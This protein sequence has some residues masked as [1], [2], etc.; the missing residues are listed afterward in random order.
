MTTFD[1]SVNTAWMEAL[2]MG[3][4]RLYYIKLDTNETSWECPSQFLVRA[5][6]VAAHATA[7]EQLRQH[8][9]ASAADGDDAAFLA[10][11]LERFPPPLTPPPAGDA[12]TALQAQV[13]RLEREK[14]ALEQQVTQLSAAAQKASAEKAALE[15]TVAQLNTVSASGAPPSCASPSGAKPP[16]CKR[17][18]SARFNLAAPPPPPPEWALQMSKGSSGRTVVGAMTDGGAATAP[19]AS[20]GIGGLHPPLNRRISGA[21]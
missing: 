19:S 4:G 10:R 18:A 14:A 9:A 12:S 17:G 3:S 15:Q 1:P 13:Q 5:D 11:V 6:L 7:L 2:D 20:S 16:S 21:I 8:P